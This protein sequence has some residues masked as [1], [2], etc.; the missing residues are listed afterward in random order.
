MRKKPS[1]PFFSFFLVA[2]QTREFATSSTAVTAAAAAA[3]PAFDDPHL[4]Q[5]NELHPFDDWLRSHSEPTPM[6][7]M[8]A[9]HSVSQEAISAPECLPFVST[10]VQ[11][12]AQAEGLFQV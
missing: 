3:A 11:E 8:I 6:T 4:P 12:Q 10:Q 9:Q 2:F 7:M 1:P 5:Q